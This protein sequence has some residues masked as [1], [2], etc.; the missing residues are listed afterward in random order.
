MA[1]AIQWRRGT[2]AQHSS[3]TGL[4]GE[5]TV[6]TDL[7][8]L[9]VHDGSTAGGHRLAK[10]SEIGDITAVTAGDGLSGGGTSGALSIALDLNELTAATINV[11]NDSIVLIDADDSNGSKKESVADFVS[12]IAGSGLSA[13][14]G[15][16]SISET[17]DISAVTAGDGL[18]GGGSSGAVSLALDL[19]E[20][21]AATIDVATDSFPIIDAGDN[22]SKKESI[23]DLVSA[24][25]GSGLSASNG[26]LAISETGDISAVTAGD[27][28]SGGGSSGAVSL[29]LDLNELTAASVDVANDSI[30]I[31]DAGDNSSKKESIA[32]LVTAMAG[33]N[34]TATNG[35]LSTT[36]DITG[37]TAGDG[38]SGGGTSGALSLALDLNEL[39]AAAVDVAADSI[40]II[41]GGDNSS[42]KESIADLATAMAGTGIDASSGA[43]AVDSTVVVTSGTQTVG[44]N[45]TFSNDI[46]VSGNLT[47][48]GTTTTINTETLLLEDNIITLNSGT[49]GT[50]SQNAG[51]TI[52]RG[53]S[54]DVFLQFN[55]TTNVWQ[56]T[57]DGSTYFSIATS[58]DTLAEGS[59]NL[60]FTNTRAD[61]RADSRF[62]TKLAAADTGDLSEGSNL[63]YTDERVADKIGSI[64]SGSGNISVTYDDAADTIT[65]SEALTTTDIT[66]GDNLYYTNA[67]ADARIAANLIDE[68]DLSSDSAT[69]APSQQSVKA[70]IA[71]QIATKDNSDEITEGSS[72]LYFT[73]AR[74]DARITNA[75]KDEDNMASNSATHIPSQQS[76]K[77]YVDAQVATKDALSELSG[78][79]DDVTEGSSNL[80][81]T[82]ARADARIAAADTDSLSE[83]SS[84]QYHTSGRV[85][86][87]IDARVDTAFVNALNVNATTLD[88]IDSGSFLRSDANDS[89]SGD[90]APGSDNALDLGTSSLRYAEV[91]SVLFSGVASSAKYADL[92]EKYTT[93]E[94]LDA[95]TVVCFGGEAEITACDHE[96]D[97]RVAGVISTDPAYM[98]NSEGEG[99]YLALTGRVPTKVTG[100]VAK[101][102]LL[103]SSSVKGHA[104]V[105]NNAQ[106]GRIIGKAVGSN[107]SG[108]GVIEVLVNMM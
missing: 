72:N 4:V 47:V 81:F 102:D 27:G 30:A 87:L 33:T 103:V 54:D 98:M 15:Q 56:F 8:T 19:N 49:S 1:T 25:A 77:A 60:Y 5:I 105:D 96:C 14:S 35:V 48:S 17:G 18:S 20:L 71:T 61:A 75:L 85:N 31:I 91:H 32:D 59:T 93:D 63:Y 39:T 58:T 40:A 99:Q 80:Y 74:A 41:D 52:D 12:A 62:D 43:F 92:A 7:D 34:L 82:N 86:T 11:A 68:D 73:N 37:V 36:A 108:E 28:L 70:Y 6:D 9:R 76:V 88:S 29:A 50:P 22:S 101:G 10:Y 106:P 64:L 45:K 21:T 89:H 79:T 66:E 3:F 23:A 13:S 24:I 78:D 100:P 26:V 42:K 46:V 97:H 69:R 2:T 104:M 83:G 94:E 57:N 107:E 67:R 65:V 95:G 55:E 16:L 44:G 38:L 90:I 84:N 51:I 53:S